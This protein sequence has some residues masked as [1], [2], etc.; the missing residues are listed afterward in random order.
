[1][2][3]LAQQGNDKAPVTWDMCVPLFAN[4]Q[5]FVLFSTKRN[6]FEAASVLFQSKVTANTVKVGIAAKNGQIFSK[7]VT[8]MA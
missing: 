6:S 3:H 8:K 7:M 1:M 5:Q 4:N 2:N